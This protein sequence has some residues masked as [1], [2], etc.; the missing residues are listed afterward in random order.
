LK[1][2]IKGDSIRFRLS[3]SELT[4]FGIVNFVKDKIHF[5]DSELEYS[6]STSDSNAE[7]SASFQSNL[8]T[9][10]VPTQLALNWVNTEIVGLQ[11]EQTLSNGN[12]LFILIE[13]DFVCLDNTFD[14]QSDNFPNPNIVC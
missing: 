1:L 3:K 4:A 12:K 14:D 7:I 9:V 8:I 11:F 10:N 2:R 6:I 13:K 5:A